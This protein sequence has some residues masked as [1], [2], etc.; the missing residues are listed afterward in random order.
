MRGNLITGQQLKA[1]R[2]LVGI[3]QDQLAEAAGLHVNSVRYLERQDRIT[4]IYS[5]QRVE[6][7]MN[8][9]GVIFLT[10]PT[11]GVRVAPAK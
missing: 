2:A 3:G 4:T 6:T 5:R 9:F 7:A 1:A 11:P 10:K 8:A